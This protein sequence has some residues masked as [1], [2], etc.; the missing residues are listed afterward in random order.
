MS[1]VQI[2]P[3]IL[4]TEEKDYKAKIEK[5]WESNLFDR[6]VVQLDL[7]DGEFVR[8]KSVGVEVV[9]R[10]PA[11]FKYEVHLMV[12]NPQAW[13]EDLKGFNKIIRFIVP[14][15]LGKDRLDEFI[16][17]VRAFTDAEI[18]FSFNPKTSLSKLGDYQMVAEAILI[19][20]VEPGFGGQE[21]LLG[22]LGK[23]GEAASLV[24][25][26]GLDCL[27]GVDGGVNADN[28]KQIVEAGAD[29]I[30]VGSSLIDGDIDEN[31]R[32]IQNAI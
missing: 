2:V 26:N 19:M 15:E 30:V 10:Y 32:K 8:N 18:G 27:I 9:K 12:S 24:K 28:V 4:A 11:S 29:Y 21:F 5:L 7:M 6:D 23:T 31:L 22:T 17:F 13:A 25:K 3:A 16:S 20:G 14:I 1:K